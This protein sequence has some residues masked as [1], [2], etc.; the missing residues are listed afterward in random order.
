MASTP[1]ETELYL[2]FHLCY[3]FSPFDLFRVTF[4]KYRQMLIIASFFPPTGP[5]DMS[6]VRFKQGFQEEHEEVLDLIW[7]KYT[8]IA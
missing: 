8:K 7:K 5:L 2:R 1:L 4:I 3:A 6:H